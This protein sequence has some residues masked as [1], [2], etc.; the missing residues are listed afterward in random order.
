MI[1]LLIY[2]IVDILSSEYKEYDKEKLKEFIIERIYKAFDANASV[3]SAVLASGDRDI[4]AIAKKVKA[5]HEIVSQPNFKE[6]FS[7]FKR[8][9]NISKDIDL[10]SDLCI[11]NTLFENDAEVTLYDEY[12]KVINT[13]YNNYKEKLEAL[14]GLKEHLDRYFDDVM[15][16]VEDE[17]IKANRQSMVATIYKTFKEIADIKEITV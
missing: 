14:F 15:V 9:A 2:N 3:I 1:Y 16:N 13:P 10:D 12:E 6:L 11:D 7:T 8:V 17:K 5:L 4:N